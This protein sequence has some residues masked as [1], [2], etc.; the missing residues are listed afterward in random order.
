MSRLGTVGFVGLGVMGSALSGHLLRA[1]YEV[2]GY[3]I[4]PARLAEHAA[5]GGKPA[6]GPAD[7]AARP[8]SWSPRCRRP[9]PSARWCV[10]TTA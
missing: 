8:R 4:A 5:A 10:A 9:G 6:D 2:V 1:G 3:D 7:V